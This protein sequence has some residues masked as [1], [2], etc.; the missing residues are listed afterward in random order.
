MTQKTNIFFA[1]ENINRELDYRIVLAKYL[2]IANTR[3]IF[4]EHSQVMHLLLNGAKGI[5]IGKD[6]LAPVRNED[7]KKINKDNVK[8]MFVNEE[9]LFL[10][11]FQSKWIEELKIKLDPLLVDHDVD[12]LCPGQQQADAYTSIGARP[13]QI[14]IVGHPRFDLCKPFFADYFSDEV[15][16]IKKKFGN[17]ILFNTNFFLTNH[18][19]GWFHMID[20][21]KYNPF[22][23]TDTF[24]IIDLKN[25]WIDD[26]FRFLHFVKLIKEVAKT[27]PDRNIIIRPHLSEGLK[28]YQVLFKEI[29]N[30]K[31]IKK[32]NVIPWLIG[33]DF[34]V[35]QGCT[36]SLEAVL[37]NK[38]AYGYY[39]LGD[40]HESDIMLS[41]SFA[42]NFN[43]QY[44]LIKA[45]KSVKRKDYS[46]ALNE[47][48]NH[49]FNL[50]EDDDF[51]FRQYQ[52]HVQNYL[53][54]E[55]KKDIE[56]DFDSD[57]FKTSLS[58]FYQRFENKK[59]DSGYIHKYWGFDTSYIKGKF[60][61]LGMSMKVLVEDKHLLII[62]D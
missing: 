60:K 55:D 21:T 47:S 15:S 13:E 14:K 59:E 52:A 12:I 26:N 5:Y 34:L 33:C 38:P 53:S 11:G 41:R 45:T 57:L 3:I 29:S 40:A 36:T 8:F 16:S 30:I 10:K 23:D 32:G 1:I 7:Y 58:Y 62:E 51:S 6:A 54:S 28:I 31:V 20:E 2:K 56:S 50:R 17:Y 37:A 18:A 42:E 25:Y 9:G 39:P 44:D 22:G 19:N 43:E 61:K 48:S 24:S 49:I 46:Q 4:A 35:Q 27:H